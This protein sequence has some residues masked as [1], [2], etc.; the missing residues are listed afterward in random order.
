MSRRV[1]LIQ[2]DRASARPLAE[3][4]AKQGDKIWE[5]GDLVEARAIM[6]R[7][8]PSLIFVDMHIPGNEL[9]GTLTY[10]R[11]EHPDTDVV[12]TNEHPDLHREMLIMERG[13]QVFLRQPFTL[14]WIE[15]ALQKLKH[16]VQP[17]PALVAT[18]RVLPKVRMPMRI[19]ITF[20][21][22][23]L[24]LLF[25]IASLFLVSRYVFES[26]RD[27][28]ISQL[29][30]VGKLSSDWMVQEES[31]ILETLR[32]LANTEGISEAI[33]G[34]DSERLREIALPVAINYQEEAVDFLDMQG[35]SLLSIHHKPDGSLI[36]YDVS[37]GD[38][39]LASTYFV[40]RVLLQN[41][42]LRGDKYAGL[43]RVPWGDF[44]YI[45][46]PIMDVDGNQVGVLVVGKSLSTLSNQ[47]RRDTLAHVTIYG[48]DGTVIFSTLFLP[49]EI[50]PLSA[51]VVGGVLVNQDEESSI[52]EI[53]VASSTY[54][55]IFGPW[56]ARGGEDLAVVGVSLAQNLLARPTL[57]TRFQVFSFVIV[58]FLGV[59]ALGVFLAHQITRPLSGVVRASI[60]VARG[61][62]E[63][64]VPS[65]GNDEIMVLAHAFN[66]MVSGLQEGIIYRDLLG[67]TVSPEV[68]DA[69][70][71]SFASGNLRLEGQN[72]VATVLMSDI[73]G[74]TSLSEKEEPTTI[75]N[76]LNE[77]FGEIV[78]VITSHRG[79]VDKFE[80]DAM[81]AFFG[82]LPTI[83]PSQE[84][85]HKACQSAV[86][87]LTVIE[88]INARRV[89]REE[90]P[91]V[92]GIGI[93]TGSL[94]AGGLGTAD[95]LNYTIIGDTVNTTQRIEGV[96]REFGE[97]G[98]IV[99]ENTINALGEKRSEFRFEPLGEHILKGKN[100]PIWLYRLLPV[101]NGG[102]GRGTR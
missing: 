93:N 68:R 67:R 79:V 22:A 92:T 3:Y 57:I 7:E 39:S 10:V 4:F 40:K 26:M 18:D 91:L 30:D 66:R 25:A 56:E 33:L 69:L 19:K 99:S 37:Q 78:P 23:L 55:E 94:T 16:K 87:M 21:Y 41:E 101:V 13:F 70:R 5:T 11:K 100:E 27:R 102:N 46:G 60:E 88:Q 44:F 42:D 49:Q 85:A 15:R 38:T 89:E 9:F 8:H 97:S 32:L 14:V 81:I 65:E 73:R 47:I 24:A 58:A 75:L 64:K 62:L 48:L 77:Y 52:R 12:I 82:I 80:G 6:R 31:R 83:L 28:F 43:A 29:V 54:S 86:G 74:F 2:S 34:Q 84:S 53:T 98:V 1:L 20:P 76:W 51:E 63:V 72:A 61:N 95:R 96:T 50:I 71:K 90:P 45:A 36:D 17:P 59:I 35:V